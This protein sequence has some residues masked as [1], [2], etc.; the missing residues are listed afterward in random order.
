MFVGK[1]TVHKDDATASVEGSGSGT[2]RGQTGYV[3]GDGSSTHTWQLPE[4]GG[5]GEQD[6]A[7]MTATDGQDKS[8]SDS[9]PVPRGRKAKKKPGPGVSR[10]DTDNTPH[11]PRNLLEAAPLSCRYLFGGLSRQNP[12][13]ILCFRI[14]KQPV[15]SFLFHAINMA[16]CV[17]T[18]VA[19]DLFGMSLLDHSVTLPGMGLGEAVMSTRGHMVRQGLLAFDLFCVGVL[20][21]EVAIGILALGFSGHRCVV[22]VCAECAMRARA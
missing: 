21:L 15:F 8:K 1:L 7:S 14:Y 13:R 5:V 19:P 20:F 22:C 6:T 11:E 4:R 3:N 2:H 16:N 10:S 17:F 18:A 12:L 9:K